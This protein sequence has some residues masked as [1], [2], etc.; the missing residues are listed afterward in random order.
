MDKFDQIHYSTLIVGVDIGKKKH[1]ARAVDDRGR[2][3]AKPLS[4]TNTKKRVDQLLF[5]KSL[6]PDH[7]YC[8]EWSRPGTIG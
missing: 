2:E 5:S 1:V 4:F 8:L 6:I 7:T 3:L